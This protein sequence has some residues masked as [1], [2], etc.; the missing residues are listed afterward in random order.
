MDNIMLLFMTAILLAYVDK[1]SVT[2]ND[3][4]GSLFTSSK[5]LEGLILTTSS[6]VSKLD[7]YIELEHSRIAKLEKLLNDYKILHNRAVESTEKFVGNPLNSFLLIK[8]L[9]SDWQ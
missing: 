8:K 1:L 9:T 2:A 7:N 4:D 3:D 6:I 5:D